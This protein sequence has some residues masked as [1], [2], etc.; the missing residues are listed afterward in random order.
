[1]NEY[2]DYIIRAT[3]ADGQVRAF[4]ATTTNLAAYAQKI[5]G[6]SPVAAAAL[7]RLMTAAAMMGIDM[8]GEGNSLSIILKG[9]GPLGKIVVLA[10][11]NGRIKGYV[12][13]PDVYLPLNSIGKLDV[14]AGVGKEGKLTVIKDLGLKEPYV[15]QVD[16]VSG[17]IGEDIA[18]YLAASEQKPAAV[19]LGVLVDID[20]T[21]IAA[22]GFMIQPL[23]GASEEIIQKIEHNISVIP[24]VSALIAEG[25]TPE[26]ILKDLLGDY[27]LKVYDKIYPLFSCDCSRERLESILITLG[28]DELEDILKE[29]GKAELV[30]QYCNKKYVFDYDDIRELIE[31]IDE[32]KKI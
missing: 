30:C 20:S 12:D 21:V 27:E 26:E 29:D 24:A 6:L 4:A 5:H 17:E 9:G 16:I 19:G 10:N 18:F 22:G 11:S 13:N 1:M 15:G 7:G 31:R 25:K 23:P 32:D 28:R 2:K 3:A 14:S 8:K